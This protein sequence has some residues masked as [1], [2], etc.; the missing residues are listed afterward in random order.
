MVQL[1]LILE[2]CSR[3][4][5][6]STAKFRRGR[7]ATKFKFEGVRQHYIGKPIA[8]GDPEIYPAVLIINLA[9]TKTLL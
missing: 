2:F 6:T 9:S 7:R 8:K 3:G 4:G 5:K 1:V